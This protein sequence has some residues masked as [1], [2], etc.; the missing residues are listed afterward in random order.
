MKDLP[1]NL[2]CQGKTNGTTTERGYILLRIAE[3]GPSR[4][5]FE[6]KEHVGH[7]HL[8]PLHTRMAKEGLLNED[9]YGGSP[10]EQVSRRHGKTP[11]FTW[12]P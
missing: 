3:R 9:G 10:M 1:D 11:R 5:R 4:C 8:C 6:A 2:R 12:M 7:L